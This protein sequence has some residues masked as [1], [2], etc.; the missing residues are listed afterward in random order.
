MLNVLPAVAMPSAA[1][2]EDVAPTVPPTEYQQQPTTLGS[3]VRSYET[4]PPTHTPSSGRR[5]GVIGGVALSIVGVAV[6]IAIATSG[7]KSSTNN[8]VTAPQ[9]TPVVVPDAP[10]VKAPEPDAAPVVAVDAAEP[11]DAPVDAAEPPADAKKKV[12]IKKPRGGGQ[13]TEDVGESRK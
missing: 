1:M 2:H 6:A 8:V 11:E 12:I 7:G 4:P 5:W 3:S 9:P 10:E 13:S